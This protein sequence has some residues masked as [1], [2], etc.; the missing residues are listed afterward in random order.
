[1]GARLR[2]L[3]RR[4]I[5]RIG[6]IGPYYRWLERRTAR[7]ADDEAFVDDGRP[8]PS[9]ELVM[10]VSGPSRAWFSIQGC[11]HAGF[12]R[13]VAARHGADLAAG[14]HVL[15]FGCG[16]GR[17]A[18]WLAPEVTAGGGTFTGSDLNPRLASWCAGHLPGRYLV[19]GL[20]PPL[21]LPDAG[22]DLVYAYSVLTHLREANARAWLAEVAR[23][24]RPGGLALMSFHD[25]AYAARWGPPGVAERL[26]A[27]PYVIWNDA[28]EGSNYLSAWTTRARLAALAEP[29]FEVLE[30]ILGATD[31]PNQALAVLR[32]SPPSC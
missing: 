16:A 15:D 7:E 17:I 13:E 24:L 11:T 9:A 2:R 14:L 1:M 19:N 25:E 26:A 27:T 29:G 6:L 12:I 5:E 4:A 30:M 28:L 21:D 10:L 31:A 22:L 23:V 32:A 18:R 20:R 3:V 8:M